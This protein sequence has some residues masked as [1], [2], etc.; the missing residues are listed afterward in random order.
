[1]YAKKLVN[2]IKT[3]NCDGCACGVVRFVVS[4][5]RFGQPVKT[6]NT[7]E[8]KIKNKTSNF[9]NYH[10]C[11]SSRRSNNE[12]CSVWNV[13][14]SYD[15]FLVFL[16]FLHV[17]LRV[18]FVLGWTDCRRFSDKTTDRPP[19]NVHYVETRFGFRRET[20]EGAKKTDAT[21]VFFF[22]FYF[23]TNVME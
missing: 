2:I 17:V 11:F 15:P 13:S 14:D 5:N 12:A 4:T 18:P 7:I 22:F 16:I 21:R 8:N 20:I 6:N 1:M 23:Q 10:V 9:F 19:F 3:N